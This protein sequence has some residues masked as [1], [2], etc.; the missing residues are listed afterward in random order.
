MLFHNAA[1]VIALY[2]F[3]E[4]IAFRALTWKELPVFTI[5]ALPGF[6]WALCDAVDWPGQKGGRWPSG[7]GLLLRWPCLYGTCCFHWAC[8]Q[9]KRD[10]QCLRRRLVRL[11]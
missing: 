6:L 5:M 3:F 4:G 7:Q 8:T 2:V 1:S 9:Q 10:E 11:T